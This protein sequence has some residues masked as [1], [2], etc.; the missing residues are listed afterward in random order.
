M[1]SDM[2]EDKEE[3]GGPS[4]RHGHVLWRA[5]RSRSVARDAKSDAMPQSATISPS[6]RALIHPLS[7]PLHQQQHLIHQPQT[8]AMFLSTELKASTSIDDFFAARAEDLSPQ[9]HPDT[10][11]LSFL[12]SSLAISAPRA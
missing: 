4:P 12:S 1:K 11:L 5:R 3:V 2:G 6:R 10:G 9:F 7:V 8:S